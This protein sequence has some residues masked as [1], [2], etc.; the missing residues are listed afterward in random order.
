LLSSFQIFALHNCLEDNQ[1]GSNAV[2]PNDSVFNVES[3]S[4]SN[5]SNQKRQKL[6][7]TF[8][9]FNGVDGRK[10]GIDQKNIKVD[11]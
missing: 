6:I 8:G 1:V 4:V 9:S 5:F 10:M 7:F 11:V 3:D 2:L